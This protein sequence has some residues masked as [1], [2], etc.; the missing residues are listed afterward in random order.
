MI[1]F[2]GA[3][4]CSTRG[5]FRDHRAAEQGGRD[6]GQDPGQVDLSSPCRQLSVNVNCNGDKLTVRVKQTVFIACQVRS[7]IARRSTSLTFRLARDQTTSS[8]TI[9]TVRPN[10]LPSRV[11]CWVGSCI[12]NYR[13]LS[14]MP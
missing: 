13:K 2:P 3:G 8:R 4:A 6:L 5:S 12:G 7:D 9:K 1:D 10:P 14:V 11:Q